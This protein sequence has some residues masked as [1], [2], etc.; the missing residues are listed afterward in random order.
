MF[1]IPDNQYLKAVACLLIVYP[2]LEATEEA[3]LEIA[4]FG[5][6]NERYKF[7][8]SLVCTS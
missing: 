5:T 7:S 8:G 1:T 6:T 2:F 3:R 4:G